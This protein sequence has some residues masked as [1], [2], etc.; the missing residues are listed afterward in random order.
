MEGPRCDLNINECLRSTHDC[1]ANAACVDLEGGFSCICHWGFTAAPLGW[2]QTGCHRTPLLKVS[3]LAQNGGQ[4]HSC[5]TDG[6]DC[7]VSQEP[8]ACLQR[9]TWRHLPFG[10]I[11]PLS[12]G[13]RVV[14]DA[15][16]AAEQFLNHCR[17]KN[18]ADWEWDI[19]AVC[20]PGIS[21]QHQFQHDAV[22]LQ[23][24]PEAYTS[25][26]VQGS[27]LCSVHYPREAPGFM[28]IPSADQWDK[29]H[30]WCSAGHFLT[31]ATDNLFGLLNTLML[32]W[33][34]PHPLSQHD[35]FDFI[36]S[37]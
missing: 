37:V 6:K 3:T 24:L 25:E 13:A 23:A 20:N 22:P 36:N 12:H 19:W 11:L 32:Y 14:A 9:R 7:H 4:A 1:P 29:V 33:V 21:C 15:E 34:L 8:G 26:A 2:N 35:Y 18:G 10:L 31:S 17:R 27:L 28:Y 5:A 16:S 30:H